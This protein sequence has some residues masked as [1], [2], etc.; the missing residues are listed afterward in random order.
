MMQ[1]KEAR[2]V[3][4][5]VSAWPDMILVLLGFRV[6]GVRGLPSFIKIGRGLADIRRG[7]PDGLL[8]SDQCFY[9][10]NHVGIRQYWRDLD[11]LEAFTRSSP[12]SG[13]W[14]EFLADRHGNGFWHEAFS[15]RGG[16][17]AIY[18]DMPALP[19]AGAFAPAVAAQGRLLSSRGRLAR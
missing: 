19:G 14:R 4:V 17:E 2:R 5:D 18:V 12:H 16:M 1:A 7:P 15:A 3:T 11:S 6:G 9:A 10:W 13:W 8:H